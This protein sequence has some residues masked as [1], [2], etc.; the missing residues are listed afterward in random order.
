MKTP[1]EFIN[2]IITVLD[3]KRSSGCLGGHIDVSS[4]RKL[5]DLTEEEMATLYA[6]IPQDE[7][8]V[9]DNGRESKGC[10]HIVSEKGYDY[11]FVAT[12]TIYGDRTSAFEDLRI[13]IDNYAVKVF[14]YKNEIKAP[15]VTGDAETIARRVISRLSENETEE[16]KWIIG[17]SFESEAKYL[18]KCIDGSLPVKGDDGL[19]YVFIAQEYSQCGGSESRDTESLTVKC[20]KTG[21]NKC[22]YS[23][24]TYSR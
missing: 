3:E 17:G 12:R 10:I 16:D 1:E 15:P 22:I 23:S 19:K 8:N 20:D 13:I 2:Y 7:K 14:L 6:S 4:A 11:K 18:F 24:V 9:I 5:L 21:L